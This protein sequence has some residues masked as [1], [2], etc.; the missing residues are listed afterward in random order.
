[1]LIHQPHVGVILQAGVELVIAVQ[2]L[3]GAQPAADQAGGL[4]GDG[5]GLPVELGELK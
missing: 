2:V 5:A 1:M 3:S 4:A